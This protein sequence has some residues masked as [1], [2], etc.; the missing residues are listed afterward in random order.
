MR[1]QRAKQLQVESLE[2][3]VLLS[4]G[5]SEPS[6]SMHVMA[7]KSFAFNGTLY[8]AFVGRL[9]PSSGKVVTIGL[10]GEDSKP[11][12]PMG[13]HVR[14]SGVFA[15]HGQVFPPGLP[16]LSDTELSLDN[17]KGTL[18]VTFSPSTTNHYR[19]AISGGTGR[20]VSADGT[21][22]NAVF[23]K[24]PHGYQIVFKSDTH[25]P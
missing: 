6:Q 9:I 17:A 7:A 23:T 14:M 25:R 1:T 12:K 5:I 21:T 4:T 16:D 11:F 20:F 18:V 8:V 19:F 13:S 3:K 24:G 22:G 2:G 15:R 10:A